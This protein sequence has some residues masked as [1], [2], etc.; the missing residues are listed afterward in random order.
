MRILVTGSS[1]R[2]G[3]AIVAYLSRWHEVRGLDRMAGSC[4]THQGDIRDERLVAQ[5]VA[6]VDVVIHTASLHA[7]HMK[8]FSERD[9]IET[10]VYGTECL[11]AVCL[12]S[13]VSRFVYTSTTSLYGKAMQPDDRAVWVTEALPPQPRD[14]YDESKIAAEKA[15][16]AASDAGLTCLSLRV[17]RCFPEAEHLMAIY[18]LYRAVDL[19]DVVQAHHLAMTVDFS[20]FGVFNIS[21]ATPFRKEETQELIETAQHVIMRH[22]PWAANAFHRRGWQLPQM[23]DRVYVTQKAQ[24]VLGYAPKYTFDT[25]F[26]EAEKQG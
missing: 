5:A 22:F 9:F 7:P 8:L 10:N 2:F 23:I 17:S 11:L 26:D 19:R 16:Q 25:L 18:R 15:C 13:K 24:N 3:A 6:G 1:G 21:S 20:G 4:T 14:I 12:S